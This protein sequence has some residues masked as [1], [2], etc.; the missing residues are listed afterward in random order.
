[1]NPGGYIY[2]VTNRPNGVLYVGFTNDLFRRITEHKNKHY[3]N[4]FS[5]QYNLDKLV[6]FEV[7]ETTAEAYAREQQ[8]K[9]GNRARKVK[10]IE[11][12]NP[13]WRDLYVDLLDS[14]RGLGAFG[15]GRSDL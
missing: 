2:I 3:P 13:G 14:S 8:L 1:M 9:A 7:F 10:L 15:R 12:L 6:Y 4:A 5:A 11:S